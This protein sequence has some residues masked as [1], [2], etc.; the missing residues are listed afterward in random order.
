MQGRRRGAGR[1]AAAWGCGQAAPAAPPWRARYRYQQGL[2]LPARP[3]CRRPPR[4]A[5]P[6]CRAVVAAA[7][8]AAAG[9][10]ADTWTN[11]TEPR[12]RRRGREGIEGGGAERGSVTMA[13]VIPPPPAGAVMGR[14]GLAHPPAIPPGGGRACPAPRPRGGLTRPPWLP[15]P[16]GHAGP[17]GAEP[18]PPTRP[19]YRSLPGPGTEQG[20]VLG[21]L[22]RL[23][24]GR[25]AHSGAL[26]C[27]LSGAG[28]RGPWPRSPLWPWPAGAVQPGP[29]AARS[30]L[31][32]PVWLPQQVCSDCT[33]CFCV[34]PPGARRGVGKGGDSGNYY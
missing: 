22:P 33:P 26:G 23:S 29:C 31:P 19:Q 21:A 28:L 18:A 2:G 5:P 9:A 25:P 13:T 14:R 4:P 32:R 24:F 27:G 15:A 20:H 10:G 1:G 3:F 11:G 34:G 12:V 7:D 17:G 6:C 8:W 16:A 30:C